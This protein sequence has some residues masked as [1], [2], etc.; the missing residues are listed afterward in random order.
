MTRLMMIRSPMSALMMSAPP[1]EYQPAP[2]S[3]LGRGLLAVA[4]KRKTTLCAADVGPLQGAARLRPLPLCRATLLSYATLTCAQLLN[5][6]KKVILSITC[7]G[8][9]LS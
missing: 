2:N 7:S 5:H 3:P 8:R 6:W 1:E 9:G 4:R